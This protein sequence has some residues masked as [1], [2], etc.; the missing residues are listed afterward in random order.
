MP[1]RTE[2]RLD[3]LVVGYVSKAVGDVQPQQSDPGDDRVSHL[4]DWVRVGSLSFRWL[5]FRFHPSSRRG[6]LRGTSADVC[7]LPN[8]RSKSESGATEKEWCY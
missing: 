6:R 1:F 7:L 8:G 4:V 2:L 3:F 5:S